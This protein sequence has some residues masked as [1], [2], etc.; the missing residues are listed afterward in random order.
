VQDLSLRRLWLYR[1][2]RSI[3]ELFALEDEK[4]DPLAVATL[5]EMK[6]YDDL[7]FLAYL[8]ASGTGRIGNEKFLDE[9][10]HLISA[11][12]LAGF[13]HV[14]GTLWEVNDEVCVDV[15]RIIHEGIRDGHMTDESLC[16]GLHNAV[17]KPR[18]Y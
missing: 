16:E 8:S 7:S 13:R 10:I 15:A 3:Y 12:Q 5:L 11:F 1:C 9:S 17:R 6:L 2:D 14:I 4:A 18:D